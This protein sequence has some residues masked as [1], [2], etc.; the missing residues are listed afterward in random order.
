M[1][2]LIYLTTFLVFSLASLPW[3]GIDLV[4]YDLVLG[5]DNADSAR[6]L[7]RLL[8]ADPLSPRESWEDTLEGYES[9]P[10]QGLL[11]R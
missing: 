1:S 2:V 10:S 3:I 5:L 11:I 7:V 6:K 8:L 9:D 4:L